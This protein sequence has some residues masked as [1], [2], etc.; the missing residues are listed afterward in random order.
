MAFRRRMLTEAPWAFASTVDDDVALDPEHVRT[1]LADPENAVVA[2]EGPSGSGVLIAT[3]GI[4]RMKSKKFAHRSK[5]WGV[6]VCPHHRGTGLGRAVTAAA[7]DLAKG[8]NGV[9]FVDLGVSENSPE[10]RNLYA[11]FG[12]KEWGREPETT[13]HNEQRYDEI[14][15]ALRIDGSTPIVRRAITSVY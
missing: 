9:E 5:L 7:I 4:F 1:S 3:A 14:Y 10:A 12:F 6:F 8:W 11:S 13:Q 2:V 15:M